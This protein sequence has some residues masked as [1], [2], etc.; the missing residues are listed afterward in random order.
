MI[1]NRARVARRGAAAVELAIIM[2]LFLLL[3]LGCIDFGRFAYTFIS[4]TNAARAGAGAGMMG[5]YPNPD[6]ATNTGLTN[7][8]MSICNA[9]ANELGMDDDFI[10]AG[11]G[12][13]NGY[14]NSQGLYVQAILFSEAGG[15]WRAQVTARHPFAWWGIPGDAR[16]QQTVVFRAI[17]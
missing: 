6:P 14:I 2:P 7:W 4:V 13:A 15:L 11:S 9:V 8:Q 1:R 12:D 3:I 10:P 16:P 5:D 17:R